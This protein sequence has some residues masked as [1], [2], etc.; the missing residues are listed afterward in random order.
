MCGGSH[1]Q[2]L[3]LEHCNGIQ[4]M[5]YAGQ[6]QLWFW[7]VFFFFST[8]QLPPHCYMRL[9]LIRPFPHECQCK[10]KKNHAKENMNEWH[11][12]HHQK[13]STH[14]MQISAI[15]SCIVTSLPGHKLF[16]ASAWL[17]RIKRPKFF[18]NLRRKRNPSF[19][20]LQRQTKP[21]GQVCFSLSTNR[22]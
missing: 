2:V 16:I 21:F 17:T 14:R 11:E 22:A 6:R 8:T 10:K 20:Q 3:T 13:V 1:C 5:Q 4:W 7:V 12:I 19:S 15:S 18:K 9:S